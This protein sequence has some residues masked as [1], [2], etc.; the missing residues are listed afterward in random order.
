[1]R[2]L[3]I[4]SR[5]RRTLLLVVPAAIT[6]VLLPAQKKVPRLQ[7]DPD[8]DDNS[9]DIPIP[10]SN[11]QI[12]RIVKDDYEK[13]LKDARDLTG[14]ARSFEEDLEKNDAFVFSL[15]SLKK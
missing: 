4:P 3:T 15:A 6:A 13:N 8:A 14:L 11:K 5:V 9:G 12:N 10:D 7:G 2:D 1:M